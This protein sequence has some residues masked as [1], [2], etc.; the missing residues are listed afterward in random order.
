[1]ATIVPVRGKDGV[2]Y[3]VQ[4]RLKG[5][6]TESAYFKRK[7]DAKKWAGQI[8][9]AI[10]EGRYFP[11]RE[12]AKHT[13]AELID[14]FLQE[15][16]PRRPRSMESREQHLR[17]WRERLGHLRL[18]DVTPAA[19]V[20]QRDALLH[21]ITRLGILPLPRPPP[22]GGLLLGDERSDT[23]RD[24]RG[25]RTSDACHGA[26]ICCQRNMWREWWH[27]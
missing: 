8:E 3:R 19:I 15:V 7:T 23:G 2:R 6:R 27:G 9:T 12:A 4:V 14:R 13:V 16:S 21:G 22:H 11:S 20:E 17:W 25:P 18:R 5:S 1:M 26:A 24:R 10:R